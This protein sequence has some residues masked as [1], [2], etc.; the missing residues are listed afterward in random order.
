MKLNLIWARNLAHT[1]GDQGSLPWPK[2]PLDMQHFKDCTLGSTV[3]MGR[4]TWDSLPPQCKPLPVRTNI[5][6]TRTLP[7]AEPSWVSNCPSLQ[8]AIDLAARINP[9]AW[10]IGGKSLID[11]VFLEHS[12]L[13]QDIYVSVIHS[14]EP[15]ATCSPQIPPEFMVRSIHTHYCAP[16]YPTLE[17]VHYS[18]QD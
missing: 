17:I 1:F 14:S 6:V 4:A 9:I 2:H 13:V 8:A 5:V 12:D 7:K 11:Q 10:V 18:R 16:K 3:I 15:G